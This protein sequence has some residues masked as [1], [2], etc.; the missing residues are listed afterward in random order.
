MIDKK[1][2]EEIIPRIRKIK[3]QIDGVEKM[4]KDRRYCIDILQQIYAIIGGLKVISLMILK[5]HID[6]CVKEAM[7]SKNEE[8]IKE[9]IDQLIEIYKKFSK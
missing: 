5:N 3:G 9:K 7:L 2:I 4:V 6:T 1:L 8:E